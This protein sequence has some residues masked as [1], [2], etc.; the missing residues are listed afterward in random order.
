MNPGKLGDMPESMAFGLRAL[1]AVFC[2][3]VFPGWAAADSLETLVM[4]G[5]VIEGHAK[6]ERDCNKCHRAF[7]KE[8][9][10][11]LCLDCHKDVARDVRD[12]KGFHGRMVGIKERQCKDCHGEHKG[13]QAD[14][15]H[16]DKELFDHER[17]DFQLK[18]GHAKV[19]CTAC[20]KSGKK[21]REAPSQCI[22]CHR[23]EDPHQG[24][25]GE[26][27]ADCHEEST[28]KKQAF[29]HDKTGFPLRGQHRQTL[30]QSCHPGERYKDT[31]K[32]CYA[33]HRMNDI[34]AG[35]LG[36]K[37][38]DC[39]TSD[40]WK[41]PD[42][43]HN[44]DTKFMLEGGHRPVEC[45]GCHKKDP[46][47]EKLQT[48]CYACH[49]EDDTH[50]GRFGEKC[51]SCHTAADWKKTV[52]NHDKDTKYPLRGA[53]KEVKC[54]ACHKDTL[55]REKLKTECIACHKENDPHKG[56]EGER[57][58]QCHGEEG[59][60]SKVSFKHD[61]TKFPL[62]GLHAIV[63]C[64]ECHLTPKF[65]DAEVS[66]NACHK[67]DDV[68]KGS[69]GIAC[70]QCHN[71]NGWRLWLFDHD[72]QS[73][74]PLEGAH[75]DLACQ[76]CHSQPVADSKDIRLA[77]ECFSCHQK[78]DVHKSNFGQNCGRCHVESS[79]RELRRH[80]GR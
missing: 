29:N 58:E 34:H 80:T 27:C 38:Q 76:G 17:T 41:K 44:R 61:L 57:C 23:K 2:G 18:G 53:H 50:K 28:W 6:L 39:H 7:S 67:K 31:P 73:K 79:F 72:R 54:E 14:V 45:E 40:Q 12:N 32:E 3:L 37:C 1:L 56:Q 46:K 25:L 52:F 5:P 13:R 33:C 20:H 74:F 8:T 11:E 78:D 60:K 75:K 9:Q 62:I 30:C 55:Y 24:H 43:D 15:V 10:S 42:F 59:W 49:R 64:E 19:D 4:P 51:E 47:V 70:E 22:D 65:Q 71:P 21:F 77:K 16:L 69:L 35:Q 66:C 26:K 63:P 36:Q 68:H 48:R